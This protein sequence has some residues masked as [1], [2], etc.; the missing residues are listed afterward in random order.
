LKGAGLKS[1]RALALKPGYYDSLTGLPSQALFF[2]RLSQAIALASRY[3][4]T[5]AIL[6][7]SLDNLK[8]INDTV[9]Q[10]VGDLL[11]KT[12]AAAIAECLRKSDTVARPGRNEFMV[13]LPEVTLGDDASVV[14]QKILGLQESPFFVGRHDLFLSI[15]IGISVYPHDGD[16]AV[17]LIKNAYT[18]LQRARSAGNK[19]CLFYSQEMN[20]RAFN[21]MKMENSLRFALRR[22]EFFLHYQPQINLRTGTITGM[23]ALVRWNNPDCG[24][25]YP[26]DFIHIMEDTGLI[27]ELGEWVLREACAQNRKWQEAGLRSVRVSVNL[28][29]RQF[30]HHDIV[31]TVG[32][33]LAETGLDPAYLELELTE[34]VF[35]RNTGSTLE[36]LTKLRAMGVHLSLDDFGTGFSSLSYLKCFPISRLKIV[37]PF[38]SSGSLTD[39][40]ATIARAIV[41]MAHGLSIGVVAEG[42]EKVEDLE[43][44][45]SLRC[46]DV[47]GYIFSSAISAEDMMT[48]LTR[49]KHFSPTWEKLSD[50]ISLK[51]KDS[52]GSTRC[53]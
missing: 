53:A 18:A 49:E 52:Q 3:Q 47:Q 14:A 1:H 28:S 21:R 16:C 13:L 45:Y 48:A 8:L 22:K 24:V 35:M 36:A 11:L 19:A 31:T 40:E 50:H 27:V 10:S 17:E 34:N 26:N 51:L 12:V 30:H 23:E 20:E 9:G 15:R 44:I 43:F 5:A 38:I 2:D 46:D 29:P 4:K 7:I 6:F 37:A 42:V 25:V 32:R 33:A 41:A 39:S